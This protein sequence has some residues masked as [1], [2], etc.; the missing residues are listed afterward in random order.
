MGALA[1]DFRYGVRM[2]RRSPGFT[3]VAIVTLALGIGANTAIFSVVDA[4]LLRPLPFHDPDRLVMVWEDATHVG[5]PRNTPAPAN[6]LDWKAQNHTFDDLAALRSRSFNLT[7]EGDPEQLDARAVTANMFPLLGVKPALGRTFLEAEDQPGAPNVAVVSYG[8][9]QRRFGGEAA[10]VGRPIHLNGEKYVVVGVMPAGFQ[11]PEKGTDVWTPMAFTGEERAARNSHYLRVVGRL[12]PGV[13]LERAQVDMDTIARRL[14]QDYPRSNTNVG[15]L[16]ITLREQMVGREIQSGLI[17]LLA[18]VGCVLLIASANVAN[19]LLARAA[20]RR[21]E[22][23]VRAALGAGKARLAR[24]LLTEGLALA[25]LGGVAGVLLAGWSF[26]FLSGLVPGPLAGAAAVGL[27]G[28]VLGFT[29]LASLL[30]AVFFGVAPVLQAGRVD[31]REALQEGGGRG[32]AGARLRG[33]LALLVISEV[34]L[35]MVL[36]IGAG[37]LLQTFARLRGIDPG[38]RAGN[39]LTMTTALPRTKYAGLPQRAAFYEQVLARVR[40]LPGVASA[41]FVSFLP[42]TQRGGTQGFVIE[43]RPEPPPGEVVETNFRI[44]TPDYLR[45]MGIPLR[46][47]RH[48]EDRDDAET[49]PVVVVNEAMA[50]RHWPGEN[51]LGKRFRL[52]GNESESPWLIIV[53]VAGDVRQM[54]LEVPGRAEMYVPYRQVAPFLFAP[55]DLAIRTAGDPLSLAAAVRREIWAVDKE[56]PVSRVRTMEEILEIEVSQ[57]RFQTSLL[58][59]FAALALLLAALGIYGVLAYGVTQRTGEIGVRLALGAGQSQ[60]VRL[61]VGQGLQLAGL[62]VLLGLAASFAVTRLLDKLLFG[63]IPTDLGTFAAVTFGL[64]AI[65]A[66]ASYLPAQRAARVDPMT[67]LRAQ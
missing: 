54:G 25:A 49:L 13:S 60:V 27:N 66:L 8:L 48:L 4:V 6:Y 18:A 5:F 44:V 40:S 9:W 35:A 52:G 7:G 63:V 26:D 23:A 51:A 50:R 65:A 37:L 28:K 30:A 56:Q 10:L 31:L 36:L 14:Q 19:L 42:L 20:G 61:V 59:V 17:V 57:R 1:Q 2:L 15:A 22:I 43:G 58:T 24:Q 46:H 21:R 53:G 3:A 33:P 62:G 55:R 47:G 11:F 41:G 67:A 39:L 29:A 38:F 34:A 12:K 64:L 32:A 16:V 45:T